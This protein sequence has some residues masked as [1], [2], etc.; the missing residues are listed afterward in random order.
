[1]FFPLFSFF[2]FYCYFRSDYIARYGRMSERSARQKFW[3]IL[4]AVEYCHN[5]GIVHRDLKV[6]ECYTYKIIH[7]GIFPFN[8]SLSHNIRIGSLWKLILEYRFCGARRTALVPLPM[9]KTLNISIHLPQPI[10]LSSF[11]NLYFYSNIYYVRNIL[12]ISHIRI[13]LCKYIGAYAMSV[14]LLY[15]FIM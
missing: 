12:R 4:S 5:N 9:S 1:M 3:Q 15:L 10:H 6:I 7:N 14:I 8:K 11:R 13:Y 2:V